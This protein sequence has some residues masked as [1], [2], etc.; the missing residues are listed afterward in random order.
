MPLTLDLR[1]PLG[2]AVSGPLPDKSM[3]VVDSELRLDPHEGG[4]YYA[5]DSHTIALYDNDLS[6]S[7]P[8]PGWALLAELTP[9]AVATL[10]AAGRHIQVGIE[11]CP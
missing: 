2:Q 8:P 3:Q 6:Q 7:V 10:A 5:P 4:V 11:S 1:D 9:T